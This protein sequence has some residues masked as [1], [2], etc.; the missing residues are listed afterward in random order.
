MSLPQLIAAI[1]SHSWRC[2]VDM[3]NISES[4]LGEI[5][6]LLLGS[7]SGALAWRRLLHTS[8]CTTPPALELKSA[9]QL[10]AARALL[11]QH[12]IKQAFAL[13]R[14]HEIEPILIKGWSSARLYPESGLRPYGDIDLCIRPDQYQQAISLL[15]T[16][17]GIGCWVDLHKGFGWL[18]NR[19]WEEVY[20]RSRLVSLD[21][22]GVRVLREE[23]HLR[24]S[25]IHLLGHGAWRPIWLC[26][27][28]VSVEQLSKN[29]DWQV[30]L[31]NDRRRAKWV[32]SA[33]RLAHQLLGASIEDCPAAVRSARLPGWLIPNVLKHWEKACIKEHKP[34]ELIMKSLRHPS[35]L[36]KALFSRWSDPIVATINIEGEFNELPRL[37]FQVYDYITKYLSFITRLPGL[38]QGER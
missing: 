5:T 34:P 31:G 36:P 12:K 19:S 1:L 15:N 30:C 6:P 8:L 20:E 18:D 33:I 28:A 25:C 3:V 32:V 26:D 27:I 7:G 35:R 24:V 14:S 11:Y 37:P 10:H 21:N 13:L 2:P 23:D 38:I 9:Y 22:A 16:A 17:E 4:E 29:F